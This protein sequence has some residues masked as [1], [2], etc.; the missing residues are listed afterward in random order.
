MKMKINMT[1]SLGGSLQCKLKDQSYTTEL[2]VPKER[3]EIFSTE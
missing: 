3:Q 1:T 2:D